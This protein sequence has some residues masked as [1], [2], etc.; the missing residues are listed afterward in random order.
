MIMNKANQSTRIFLIWIGCCVF[1]LCGI[2]AT[3]GGDI[4]PKSTWRASASAC[5]EAIYPA[6]QICDNDIYSRWSSPASDPQW[7]QVDL[8]QTCTVSGLTIFWETG[9]SSAYHIDVSTDRTNWTEIYRTDKGVGGRDY[10]FFAPVEAQFVRI[11][12]TERGTGWGHSIWELDVYGPEQTPIVSLF[13]RTPADTQAICD[14]QLETTCNLSGTNTTELMLDLQLERETGGIRVAWGKSTPASVVLFHSPDGANW[15]EQAA[16]D[17]LSPP[18]D[19]L[20]HAPVRTRFLRLSIEPRHDETQAVIREISLLGPEYARSP[21]NEYQ[22]AAIKAPKGYYPESLHKRQVYW[23]IVGTGNGDAREALFD[24]YGNLEP[25]RYGPCIM[26]YIINNGTLYSALDSTNLTQ[27]LAEDYLPLPSVTWSLPGLQL[28]IQT[29]AAG[30]S[31]HT[32]LLSRYSLKNLSDTTQTGQIYLAVRPLQINPPWQFGGLSFITNLTFSSAPQETIFVNN[33]PFSIGLTKS[34]GFG[35]QPFCR[36][37]IIRHIAKGQLPDQTSLSHPDGCLS[38]ALKYDYALPPGSSTNII[39]AIPFYGRMADIPALPSNTS[40]NAYFEQ[41]HDRELTNWLA[42]VNTVEIS[43]PDRTV[44]NTLYSQLA[45]MMINQDGHAIQP[46]SRQY[47]RSWIRDGAMSSG[48]LLRMGAAET[49][50]DFIDWYAH[51]ITPEG[52]V[53]PSFLHSDPLDAGPGSGIEWDGQG[54]F[55]YTVMEYYRFTKDRAFL[56]RHY[57]NICQ[58]LAFLQNL[59]EKTL[60]PDY[61]CK[62]PAPERYRGILT[63]SISHEGYYPEMHSYWDDFWALKG[64]KDGAEAARIMND[65][66]SEQWMTRQYQLLAEALS[67]SITATI[68]YHHIAYIPG[69]AEKGDFDP[70]ST[71]IA[72]YPCAETNLLDPHILQSTY[73]RYYTELTNRL[74]PDWNAGFSGYE[75]RN[76]NAFVELGQMERAHFLLD[77]IMKSRRPA[78]WNHIAEVVLK[79][80]RM[81]CYIGDMPHTWAGSGIVNAVLNML[82]RNTDTRLILFKGAPAS[83]F[84]G[85]GLHLKKLPTWFGPLELRAR[86]DSTT[87]TLQIHIATNQIPPDGYQIYYPK[88][89]QIDLLFIN[90]KPYPTTHPLSVKF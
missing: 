89:L 48:A 8:T 87:H 59:R 33:S 34:S 35:V 66:T 22:L 53:P 43:L 2:A 81:G 7:V 9:F 14:G 73:Q 80:P 42:A 86:Y 72:F 19:L 64:W 90:D 16:L 45:Y 74:S 69:C 17:E 15:Q 10:I 82:V 27:H 46:G 75:I 29:L 61:L 76:V 44:A 88:D 50:R 58:S 24:E 54:A 85:E 38:G 21:L 79:N 67:N 39:L 83:W 13:P 77:Y 49:V 63:K 23:T 26:P 36:G 37:D 65:K 3:R 57:T 68:N 78:A 18:F 70:T 40:A 56:A 6:S 62:A 32:F 28:A 25:W 11:T 55:V 30:P 47:E 84:I 5:Q 60:V 12:G 31:D 51:F 20:F 71:S 1:V 52:K 4:P 41:I